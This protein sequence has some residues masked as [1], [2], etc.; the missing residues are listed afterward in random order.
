MYLS[1]QKQLDVIGK[2]TEGTEVL[3][4]MDTLGEFQ[5]ALGSSTTYKLAV[6][7]CVCV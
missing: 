7:M 2:H 6:N 1:W 3:Q 4:V 5:G